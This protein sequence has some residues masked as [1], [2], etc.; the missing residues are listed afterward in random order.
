[1][2]I[3]DEEKLFIEELVRRI[4]PCPNVSI[5]TRNGVLVMTQ[6][7]KDRIDLIARRKG[8][9]DATNLVR[10]YLPPN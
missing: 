10:F 7:E 9:R 8:L 2:D 6:A 5:K 3:T 1:M 4:S